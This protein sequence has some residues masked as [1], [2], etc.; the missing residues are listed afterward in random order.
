MRHRKSVKKLGRTVSHRKAML[1]NMMSSLFMHRRI[2]TTLTK[3]KEAR[4]HA[5][6]MITFAKR[7][8]LHARRQVLRHVRDKIAVKTL[9]DDIAPL[10][11]DRNGGYTRIIKLD[12]RPGDGAEMSILE[13]VGYESMFADDDNEGEEKKDSLKNRLLK[14][15]KGDKEKEKVEEAKS[16]DEPDNQE[17]VDDEKKVEN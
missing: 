15:S 17:E 6:K 16:L 7:G 8:D 12:R 14:R 4:R 9:F 11:Q 3:A 1:A 13:L 5:E 2:Q 10:F